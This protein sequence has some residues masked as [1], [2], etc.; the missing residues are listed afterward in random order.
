MSSVMPVNIQPP[1]S[2]IKSE[3]TKYP[4]PISVALWNKYVVFRSG[5]L[6]E[7]T[8]FYLAAQQFSAPA[9]TFNILRICFI[10]LFIGWFQLFASNQY[11]L[12]IVSALFSLWLCHSLGHPN[13]GARTLKEINKEFVKDLKQN[14]AETKEIFTKHHKED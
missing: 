7:N 6:A 11:S 1:A 8:D 5:R 12:I 9:L 14:I 2:S 4:V 10:I 3:S 13:S